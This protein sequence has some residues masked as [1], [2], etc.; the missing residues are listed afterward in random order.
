MF[1]HKFRGAVLVKSDPAQLLRERKREPREN[2]RSHFS[3]L[4]L[5]AHGSD[6][7]CW[8]IISLFTHQPSAWGTQNGAGLSVRKG[9]RRKKTVI[10]IHHADAQWLSAPE[11]AARASRRVSA[12]T[13]GEGEF[14]AHSPRWTFSRWSKTQTRV[15]QPWILNF[16]FQLV[17][18]CHPLGR[19]NQKK[20][21]FHFLSWF[22]STRRWWCSA[23]LHRT[24]D[25]L[26]SGRPD[27]RRKVGSFVRHP[28][29]TLHNL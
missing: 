9:G 29:I 28:P 18:D 26:F 4:I 22:F 11:T 3:A 19:V 7:H 20:S 17:A 10:S 14:T 23:C 15:A 13:P 2:A 25:L 24:H 16:S 8:D 21:C 1:R 27:I 5:F 6:S 12:K